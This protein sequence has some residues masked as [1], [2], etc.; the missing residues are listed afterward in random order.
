MRVFFLGVGYCARRLIA[1]EPWIEASGTVRTAERVAVLRAEGVDA[2]AF[3][4][5][6]AEPGLE[7]ALKEAEA[8]VV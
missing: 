6:R 5:A 3:D 8:I 1:R 7:R 4:G 2:Y